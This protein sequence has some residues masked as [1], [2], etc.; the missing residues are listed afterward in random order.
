VE[1][2]GWYFDLV[3]MENYRVKNTT[4]ATSA[5]GLIYA[6]DVQTDRIL[7]EGIEARYARHKAMAV[8]AQGWALENGFTLYAPEGYRSHTVTTIINREG[9]DFAALSAFLLQRDMRLANG[10]GDLKG[11]VFR[12]GHMGELTVKDLDDLFEA[13][14]EFLG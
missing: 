6:L 3:R 7:K 10:Y 4:A 5:I 13:I 11:K 1:N 2:R 12:I 8:K 14:G 9:F